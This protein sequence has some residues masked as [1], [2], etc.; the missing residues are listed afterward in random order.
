MKNSITKE[1]LKS[2]RLN[3]KVLFNSIYAI[4]MLALITITISIVNWRTGI[5]GHTYLTRYLFPLY[6]EA[7][8]NNNIVFESS[9]KNRILETVEIIDSVCT[10]ELIHIDSSTSFKEFYYKHYVPYIINNIHVLNLIDFEAIKV[11]DELEITYTLQDYNGK[12]YYF[13]AF[14]LKKLNSI[15]VKDIQGFDKIVMYACQSS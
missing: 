15:I 5:V 10:S 6:S 14:Y 4:I 12:Y 9:F 3:R 2:V 1:K 7:N 8:L 11:K 13:T